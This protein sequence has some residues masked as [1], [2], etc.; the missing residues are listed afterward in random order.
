[1]LQTKAVKDDTLGLLKH[2]VLALP[3]KKN[4]GMAW[5]KIRFEQPLTGNYCAELL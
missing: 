3:A 4:T 2:F 1:M 5:T